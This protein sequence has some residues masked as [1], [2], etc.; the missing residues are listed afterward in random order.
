[1]AAGFRIYLLIY[2]QQ[3]GYRIFLGADPDSAYTPERAM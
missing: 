2:D 3:A 1:M